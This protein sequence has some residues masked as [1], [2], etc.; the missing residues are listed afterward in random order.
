MTLFGGPFDGTVKTPNITG[1][2]IAYSY[3]PLDKIRIDLAGGK[4][5]LKMSADKLSEELRSQAECV[6]R[7]ADL[8]TDFS[9]I[10]ANQK[11][12]NRNCETNGFRTQCVDPC[13]KFV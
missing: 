11:I 6:R 1:S 5:S 12:G 9:G 3:L 2:Q 4:P 13:T 10:T 7:F 8:F